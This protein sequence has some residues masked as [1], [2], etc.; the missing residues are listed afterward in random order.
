MNRF[1]GMDYLISLTGSQRRAIFYALKNIR[2]TQVNPYPFFIR[3]EKK[4]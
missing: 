4:R 1:H 3:V 2:K